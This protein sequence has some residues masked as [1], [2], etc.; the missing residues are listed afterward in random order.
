MV[1]HSGWCLNAE[2]T[3]YLENAIGCDIFSLFLLV[4]VFFIFSC[5]LI[6]HLNC[7]MHGPRKI[8]NILFN[9]CGLVAMSSSSCLMA[10]FSCFWLV[11]LRA[12]SCSDLSKETT[13]GYVVLLC[14]YCLVL[15]FL[16]SIS[17]VFVLIP[18]KNFCLAACFGCT[19]LSFLVS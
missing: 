15:F 2:L 1:T 7:Q 9:G 5:Q 17:S 14:L 10:I 11:K 18:F 19:L 6:T 3:L 12:L 4:M 16:F 13:F 8:C